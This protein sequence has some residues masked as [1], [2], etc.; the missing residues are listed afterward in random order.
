MASQRLQGVIAAI[1]TPITADGEPD[2][3]R[4]VRHGA[5]AL[6]HGCHGLNVLGTT[7]EANSL[8]AVQRRAVMAAAAL[9]LPSERLMVGTG[10]PDLATTIDLTIAAHGLGFAAALVLP[11]Y[12]YKSVSEEGL[13]AW[14]AALVAATASTPI[15]IYLYNFPQMTG[16][17]FSP[18]LVR[19]L[20]EAFPDR[21]LGAKDSSGDLAYA[22][23]IAQIEGFD[24][25]PSSETAL[26]KAD[27]DGYVGC[28]S[29]T[30]NVSAPLVAA[31]WADRGNAELLRRADETRRAI[32]AQPLIPAVKFLVGR[33]QGDEE[34]ERVL[35]P[36][37]ALTA[38][39]K[40]ALAGLEH[41]A[42]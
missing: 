5:W 6:D 1:P 35:P 34:F 25:F 16:I 32:S 30:V 27:A 31:L 12:Y 8:S 23:A 29:A 18:S 36:H 17:A 39:Q 22:A 3:P 13:F 20:A 14:F 26:A 40:A 11:P 15:P 28:I 2:L 42:V 4:F 24:V 41:L 37:I 19:R 21:I 33:I 9:A 38:D 10:T 7:G